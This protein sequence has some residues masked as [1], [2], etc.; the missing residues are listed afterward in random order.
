M[1]DTVLVSSKEEKALAIKETYPQFDI[2][3]KDSFLA[4]FIQACQHNKVEVVE[5]L[6]SLTDKSFKRDLISA[7]ENEAF[8]I[9][10]KLD[11][12]SLLKLLYKNYDLSDEQIL[13]L[14]ESLKL[15]AHPNNKKFFDSR[16]YVFYGV[17]LYSEKKY[18]E[19]L[20]KFEKAIEEDNDYASAWHNKGTIFATLGKNDQALECYNKS[21]EFDSNNSTTWFNM[22][23]TLSTLGR[24]EEA[25]KCYD[26]SLEL[27]ST[28]IKIRFN[29]INILVKL[30]RDE[31]ALEC[32]NQIVEIDPQNG[33]G[34]YNKGALL[35][36]LNKHL[37]AIDC[38]VAAITYKPDF[39]D[40]VSNFVA[41]LGEDEKFD[42]ALVYV[43]NFL[44]VDPN[45][46]K[47]LFLKAGILLHQN[48]VQDSL[49]IIEECI[50]KAGNNKDSGYFRLKGMA[51]LGLTRPE[52]ALT[53][54]DQAIAVNP[55]NAET[56]YCKGCALQYLEKLDEEKICNQVK[57]LLIEL[58]PIIQETDISKISQSSVN[59]LVTK[60]QE[61]KP[62]FP[63][64]DNI[65]AALY[66]KFPK[67][68][69]ILK[70]HTGYLEH[71]DPNKAKEVYFQSL[72]C[73]ET[74]ETAR[75][76]LIR[77]VNQEN[78]TNPLSLKAASAFK[79]LIVNAVDETHFSE[80]EKDSPLYKGILEIV[81]EHA[82]DSSKYVKR[83]KENARPSYP[84]KP[85]T[86]QYRNWRE[87]V[88]AAKNPLKEVKQSHPAN[89]L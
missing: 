61:L 76:G 7:N 17:I 26:E 22:G 72:A 34:W 43:N 50:Q 49:P 74:F 63:N 29:K 58:E 62:D 3:N 47:F 30:G 18:S 86:K 55:F 45:F 33:S 38:F 20:T 13:D 31:E 27:D 81:K 78:R 51:L 88:E 83:S 39:K 65:C 10:A 4:T 69:D 24:N 66:K 79:L 46:P 53:C 60:L 44:K 57:D 80:E 21:L 87:L 85:I 84:L 40:R 82:H 9:A 14:I 64:L 71:T 25:L 37:E 77:V 5:A 36:K 16:L 19:A 59:T 73:K 28:N 1:R 56:W 75:V 2:L 15:I 52:E 68:N 6:L 41:K 8:Y 67:N 12:S 42:Q 35:F 54:F 70:L 48:N 89:E 23:N 32:Y 11:D